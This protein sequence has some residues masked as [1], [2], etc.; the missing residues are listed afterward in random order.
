[1]YLCIEHTRINPRTCR[2]YTFFK[3]IRPLLSFVSVFA[4]V[5]R[6]SPA[7]SRA[8]RRTALSTPSRTDKAIID[9][10]P[11]RV[12][13]GITLNPNIERPECGTPRQARGRLRAPSPTVPKSTPSDRIDR[14][15]PPRPPSRERSTFRAW[16][17]LHGF[18]DR[19][20]FPLRCRRGVARA[21]ATSSL[22]LPPPASRNGG[23]V[24]HFP[25]LSS[26]RA[27]RVRPLVKH[28]YFPEASAD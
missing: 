28:Y 14:I 16:A 26:P 25:D 12:D 21:H 9:V 2:F 19:L 17:S 18:I 22:P 1:V 27:D 20:P 11:R 23:A 4:L 13:V 24:V 3:I 15:D 7:P 10:T 5:F 8:P 6:I